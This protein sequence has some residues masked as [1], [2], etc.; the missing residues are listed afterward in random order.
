MHMNKQKL[1]KHL[2][3]LANYEV[4]PVE[5]AY[6][7]CWEIECG[8]DYASPYLCLVEIIIRDWPRHSGS[9]SF[10]IGIATHRLSALYYFPER[11]GFTMWGHDEYGRAR[12]EL[13]GY[14]ADE[15]EKMW[16]LGN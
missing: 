15:L 11:Y 9:H 10:P 3:A 5:S 2:R 4:E 1:I 7:L 6:G 8:I 16:E 12:R 14:V 13:C